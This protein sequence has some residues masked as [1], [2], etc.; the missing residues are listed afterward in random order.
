MTEKP[1]AIRFIR[2]YSHQ[3]PRNHCVFK[4]PDACG[5][6]HENSAK[7]HHFGHQA[8]SECTLYDLY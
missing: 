3:F 2:K 6:K 1:I 4:Y 5:L 8:P 7:T